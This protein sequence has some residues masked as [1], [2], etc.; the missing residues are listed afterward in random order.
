MGSNKFDK[1]LEKWYG[2][3]EQV[4]DTTYIIHRDVP[5]NKIEF[6]K[7]HLYLIRIDQSDTARNLLRTTAVNWNS[8]RQMHSSY[9]KCE[10]VGDLGNMIK[11]NGRGFSPSSNLDT[12]DIYLNYWL[13]KSVV[14]IIRE[15]N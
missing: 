4:D 7:N 3:V 13:D 12:D 11:I 15:I 2:V 6:R 10:Y 14:E 5:Q 8:G 9:L 1:E